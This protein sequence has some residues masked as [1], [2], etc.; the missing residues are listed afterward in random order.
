[1]K[2]A[3][4]VILSI[5]IIVGW[6]ISIFGI[7]SFVPLKDQIKLGL[8]LSGGVYVVME[9]QTD[10]EGQE[11]RKLMEQTQAIIEERVNQ[12][13]LSEPIVTTE[14]ENRIRVELPGAE[15][16]QEAIEA[17]GQTAQL[18]F[19]MADNTLVLDGSQIEDAGITAD[20]ERGGF[21]VTLKFNGE[22]AKAFEEA[23][24]RIVSGQ[25]VSSDPN[26]PSNTIMIV[27]D[28]QIISAPVVDDIIPNGEA[29]I[30]GG[31][32][33]GF[34]SSEA[35]N[36]S[37]LIRGG[38]LPVELKEVQTSVIG[39]TLGLGALEM[40]I[41]G[42]FIG[43]LLI[44][45]I[46]L[47]IYRFMGLIANFAL[48][49]YVLIV[50]WVL[51]LINAVL[52][53]PGIAGIILS[54]GMAVD[55]NVIIFSRIREEIINGKTIRV[56][57]ASG[58]KRA[59][60]T[61]IDSQLTTLIAGLVLYQFGSGPV[62]GFAL[63]LMIGI[64]VSIFTAVVVTQIY[65]SLAAD[66]A[67][68]AKKKN[69]AVKDGKGYTG[70]QFSFLKH[71]KVYSIVAIAIIIIGLGSGMVRGYNYGIDFTGGTMFQIDMGREVAVADLRDV[72]EDNNVDAD[73]V[74]AGDNNEQVIIKTTQAL[75]SDAR[76]KLQNNIF[77]EFDI[78]QSSLLSV[79]Q[80]GPSIGDMLKKNAVISVLLAGL[81]ILIYIIIRF[82]WKF[83]VAAIV[84][85]IH[86]V[87]IM[88][89]FYGLFHVTVNNPFIAV[90]L[91]IVGYSIN[92]TIVVFDRVRE[93]LGIMKKNKLEEL[94][95]TSINQ[96]LSRSLTTSITTVAAIIPLFILGGDTIRQFTLPLIIGIIAGTASSIFISNPIYYQLCQITRGSKYK[97]KKK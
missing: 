52:T 15:N 33:G 11:L 68:I 86:D 81:G 39:P 20:Q 27:L 73:V 12:M 29:I 67:F 48:I 13:G 61:I 57:V 2:K 94:I 62:K 37:I 28:G 4:A 25:V 17:I 95:N 53:L 45:I 65:L 3:L 42:G 55:A 74:H 18:Q 46:M 32:G 36:L 82:E 44:F 49:F 59:L 89:A 66:V 91:T 16:A 26:M 93:N 50:F 77:E 64:V 71:S 56:S 72:L 69:F 88:I 60:S 34:S 24:R 5:I 35:T 1:M 79:E 41:V 76:V 78:E 92:D 54:V 43:I 30:T 7:G 19:I 47:V 75:D 97:G 90:V 6:Y 63:T 9:A 87:L 10:A 58:F 14:G 23:T 80:F 22:G 21:A 40:S 83:G 8:D 84:A 31:R 96:T 38:A 85:L 51:V 70:F